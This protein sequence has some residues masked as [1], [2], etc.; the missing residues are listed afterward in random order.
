[1]MNLGFQKIKRNRVWQSGFCV[2]GQTIAEATKNLENV[3]DNEFVLL[4]VG[5]SDII[6]G[7]ELIEL[8]L[9]MIKLW[10]VCVKQ[11][12]KLIMTTL[13]PLANYR[14]GNR[15]SVTDGFNKFLLNNPFDF[16]VIKIH[17]T[18]LTKEGTMNMSCYQNFPRKVSGVHKPI[19]FW[20]R[21]G[22]QR[23]MKTLTR[24]LG[25]AILK[26]M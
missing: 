18:M 16:P 15:S 13:P 12:L 23:I 21:A 4:N 25:D 7:R 26:I 6:K 24:E 1:M 10:N 20:S 2:S 3:A 8:M 5:S 17:E 22:R 19:V 11:N 9:D 14:L